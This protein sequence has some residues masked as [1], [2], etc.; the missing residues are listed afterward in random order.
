MDLDLGDLRKRAEE[1]EAEVEGEV[2]GRSQMRSLIEDMRRR[3]REKEPSY[4]H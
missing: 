2:I 3:S 1:F 4:I